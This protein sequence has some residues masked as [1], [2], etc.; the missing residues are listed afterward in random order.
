[1]DER[2]DDSAN[3]DNKNV[4]QSSEP[5]GQDTPW[6]FRQ[7][8]AGDGD[9][10]LGGK[11]AAKK[12]QPVNPAESIAWSASEF[13][14][15]QKSAGWYAILGLVTIAIADAVYFSTHD[16]ISTGMIIFAGLLMGYY[17]SRKPKVVDYKLDHYGLSIG[18]KFYGYGDFKSF[19]LVNEGA[20]SS[21]MFMPLKRFMPALSIY[22]E[23]KDEDKI[24]NLLAP[25]LP[26]SQHKPDAVDHLMR[27]IR[28]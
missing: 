19:A 17:A 13:I 14:A 5:S 9:E 11:L 16:K 10:A 12:P 26:V 20:F 15:H 21:I 1:M 18:T 23:P 8:G 22:F 24:T 6:S 4:A 7:E 27:R 28:F 3:A 2:A 25:L